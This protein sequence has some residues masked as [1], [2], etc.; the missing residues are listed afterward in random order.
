MSKTDLPYEIIIAGVTNAFSELEGLTLVETP[1]DANNGLLAKLRNNA[2]EVSKYDTIV[3]VDDDFIFDEN[4]A[5]KFIEYSKSSGWQVLG[6]KILL[7]DGSRFWDRCTINPHKL[8]DYDYP[9]L[10][11]KIY[12]TGG[13]WIM[14]R[15]TYLEHK[16]DSS[17]PINAAERGLATH[18]EDIDMTI[19]IHN[20]GI[21]F[22]FDKDNLVW[23]NDDSYMEFNEQTFKKY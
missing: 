16:W 12:Q 2:A 22:C 5:S 8:V 17:I 19:R 1:E 20:A 9:D 21:E 11:G 23:H 7:P 4:W 18:N 13:F 15:E 6:N 3:F 10:C 14:R